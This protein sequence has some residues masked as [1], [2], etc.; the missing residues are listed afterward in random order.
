MNITYLEELLETC[1]SFILDVKTGLR[2]H[3]AEHTDDNTTADLPEQLIS[4]A[5]LVAGLSADCL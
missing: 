2:V 5:S 1:I 3:E 4:I